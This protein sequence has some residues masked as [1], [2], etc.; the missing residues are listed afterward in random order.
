MTQPDEVHR[1]GAATY[2]KVLEYFKPKFLLGMSATPERMDGFDI[3]KAFDHNI[4]YEIRLN[5][6][7]E[8]NMLCTFHYYGVSEIE[9][10]GQLLSD[11]AEFN[12]LSS[13]ERVNHIIEKSKF[14]GCD[15]S[16]GCRNPRGR[17]QV[18]M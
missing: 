8:E 3:F 4:A 17:L 16:N 13:D 11:N 12:L 15:S 5:R 1:S 7:L 6:A 2:Q 9:I 10:G 18:L 14:Y